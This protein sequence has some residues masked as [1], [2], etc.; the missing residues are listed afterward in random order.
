MK[1]NIV[2]HIIIYTYRDNAIDDDDDDE[3]YAES[4]KKDGMRKKKLYL[5]QHTHKCEEETHKKK[6]IFQGYHKE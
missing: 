4:G 1:Q 6:K 2:K 5:W 3:R